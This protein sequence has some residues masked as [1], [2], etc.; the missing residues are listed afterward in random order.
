MLETVR[1]LS[2]PATKSVRPAFV[3][4]VSQIA[5]DQKA[6]ELNLLGDDTRLRCLH[7]GKGNVG[8]GWLPM[9][10]LVDPQDSQ[11]TVKT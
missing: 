9:G 4:S 8:C 10:Y 6:F 3:G 5:P 1:P 11:D 2:T 7:G